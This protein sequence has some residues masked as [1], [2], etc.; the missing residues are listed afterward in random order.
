MRYCYKNLNI[1][2]VYKTRPFNK[3][4]NA[5]YFSGKTIVM[6]FSLC[7]ILDLLAS[8]IPNILRLVEGCN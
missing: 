3:R 8:I 6:R 1:V 2:Y 5:E 7:T 4:N